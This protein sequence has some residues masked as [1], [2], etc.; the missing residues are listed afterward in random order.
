M[1][2]AIPATIKSEVLFSDTVLIIPDVFCLV[3]MSFRPAKDRAIKAIKIVPIIAK[4]LSTTTLMTA[5][6]RLWVCLA[7]YQ[8]LIKSP[9][10]EPGRKLLKYNPRNARLRAIKN[11][12]WMSHARMKIHQ[13]KVRIIWLMMNT[14]IMMLNAGTEMPEKSLTTSWKL[15]LDA[16]KM[17]AMIATPAR[18]MRLI[19][20]FLV[21]FWFSGTQNTRK[22]LVFVK[23]SV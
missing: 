5:G 10:T 13:R 2:T 1:I 22:K 6:V 12:I 7:T 19:C 21:L 11:G 14:I 18:R 3:N 16:I 8:A 20:L 9:P 4:I 23:H 15:T 17:Q